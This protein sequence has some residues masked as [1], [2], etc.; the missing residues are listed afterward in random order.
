MADLIPVAADAGDVLP[1]GRAMVPGAVGRQLGEPA[2]I[3]RPRSL[4]RGQRLVGA[5]AAVGDKQRDLSGSE[6]ARVVG[7]Q[8][9]SQRF[10]VRPRA[11]D[12]VGSGLESQ[13]RAGCS[14]GRFPAR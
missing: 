4:R 10:D 14:H 9:E 6:P 7:A 11:R 13:H 5:Q 12:L 8:E 3:Q 1:G 2:G